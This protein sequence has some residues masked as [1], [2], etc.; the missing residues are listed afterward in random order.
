MHPLS[1]D[2]EVG[3]LVTWLPFD[4]RLPALGEP[5][6]ELARRLGAEASGELE[7]IGYK[8]R[9]RAVMR[10][11]QPGPQGLR[12]RAPI[13]GRA[14][15]PAGIAGRPVAPTAAFA[16]A[17]PE[18]RLTAQEGIEGRIADSAVDVAAEAGAMAA[19]LPHAGLAPA[20]AHPPE[21]LLDVAI[22]KAEVVETVL[23]DLGDRLEALVGPAR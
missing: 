14:R 18:L 21:K 11:G 8:Q 22:R 1:Y 9:G 7:L 6:D 20:I 13:R 23:P 19:E 17:V 10:F 15:R 12:T 16:G 5:G 3:T 4:P 2:D